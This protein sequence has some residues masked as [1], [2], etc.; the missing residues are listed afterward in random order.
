MDEH[1]KGPAPYR[2]RH[3]RSADRERLS[4]LDLGSGTLRP[5]GGSHVTNWRDCSVP[6]GIYIIGTSV[7]WD[8]S[9]NHQNTEP[10]QRVMG[11]FQGNDDVKGTAAE[12]S[13]PRDAEAL[14]ACVGPCAPPPTTSLVAALLV[15]IAAMEAENAALR[16]DKESLSAMFAAER[17]AWLRAALPMPGEDGAARPESNPFRDFSPGRRPVGG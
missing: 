2:K 4:D 5:G 6:D 7:V 11:D 10:E 1:D 14:V 17:D 16:I 15:H 9:G 12:W 8:E 3:P 13:K